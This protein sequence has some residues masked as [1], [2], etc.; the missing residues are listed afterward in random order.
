MAN[1]SSE[2]VPDNNSKQIVI[3]IP[4]VGPAVA[5]GGLVA[6]MVAIMGAVASG[7]VSGGPSGF[8][9]VT[10]TVVAAAWALVALLKYARS[11]WAPPPSRSD[12]DQVDDG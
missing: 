11:T 4:N 2:R 5:G 12:E 3:P 6:V 8:A 10:F 7:H 1:Q 9:V